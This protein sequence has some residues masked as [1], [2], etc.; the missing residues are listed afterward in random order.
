M[1]ILQGSQSAM[2]HDMI[3]AMTTDIDRATIYR[4]LNRFCEDGVT[5]RITDKSGKQFFALC[6]QCSSKE[7]LHNHLHFQCIQCEKVECFEQELNLELPKGYTTTS[8]NGIISGYCQICA[9]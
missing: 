5:H 1:S 6:K 8:F 4:I 9:N 7:H 2:S 3:F